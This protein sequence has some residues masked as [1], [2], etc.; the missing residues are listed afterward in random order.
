[1]IG[2]AMEQ[3]LEFWRI[4]QEVVVWL[5]AQFTFESSKKAG[6]NGW[7]SVRCGEAIKLR[8][9]AAVPRFLEGLKN[10]VNGLKG[11]GAVF[12]SKC[13]HEVWT[14]GLMRPEAEEVHQVFGQLSEGRG[15][16]VMVG[17]GFKLNEQHKLRM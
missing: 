12:L 6:F 7:Q 11:G 13:Q 9:V 2:D 10:M 15:L 8:E 3:L 14:D 4:A 5:G 17:F 1:M 16:V